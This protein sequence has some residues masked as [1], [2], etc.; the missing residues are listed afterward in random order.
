M[1]GLVLFLRRL[2]CGRWWW[3]HVCE[4]FPLY[5]GVEKWLCEHCG[6]TGWVDTTDGSQR[7]WTITPEKL[8]VAREMYA[9]GK[10]EMALIARTVGVSRRTLYR[11]LSTVA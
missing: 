10:H 11:Y 8:A 1:N 2:V 7:A 6:A 4:A 5:G 3:P 9:S